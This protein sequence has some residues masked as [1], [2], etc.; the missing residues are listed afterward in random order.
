MRFLWVASAGSRWQALAEPLP[1]LAPGNL[2]G[3]AGGDAGVEGLCASGGKRTGADRPLCAL[4]GHDGQAG[5]GAEGLSRLTLSRREFG[6]FL[7]ATGLLAGCGPRRVQVALAIAPDLVNGVGSLKV[8]AAEQGLY[9]GC[10]VEIAS[11]ASDA[12]YAALVRAQAGMIVRRRCND[13]GGVATGGRAGSGGRDADAL[14]AFAETNGMKVRG[15]CLCA[16]GE[17]PAWVAGA[18]PKRGA[19]ALLEEH[20]ARVAGRYT[21]RM[22]SWEVVN[23]VVRVRGWPG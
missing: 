22:H 2:Y 14:V 16:C 19:K 3:Q 9:Y 17:L 18:A 23:E 5:E 13:V 10:G 1:A 21:G 12:E 8:H 4:A 6:L 15:H 11:L 20:I 7:G